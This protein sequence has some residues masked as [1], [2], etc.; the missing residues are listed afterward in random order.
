MIESVEP[1]DKGPRKKK[2][3]STSKTPVLDN[4][5]IPFFFSNK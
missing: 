2:E 4:F 3:Q 5:S 1:N